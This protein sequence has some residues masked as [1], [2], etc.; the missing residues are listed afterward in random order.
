MDYFSGT[1]IWVPNKC[2]FVSIDN[3][4]WLVVYLCRTS[5]Y[6]EPYRKMNKFLL[7][8][9]SVTIQQ[10][11]HFFATTLEHC[12]NTGPNGILIQIFSSAIQKQIYL[13]MNFLSR[14]RTKSK[15]VIY[16]ILSICT[17]ILS[18]SVSGHNCPTDIWYFQ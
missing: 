12:F 17:S 16:D 1:N 3:P 9:R 11:F 10:I 14:P 15:Q 18:I 6:I 5:F 8:G 2:I 13:Q 4:R 7:I